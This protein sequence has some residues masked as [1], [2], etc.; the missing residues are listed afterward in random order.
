MHYT[1]FC[2]R[3]ELTPSPAWEAL[4]REAQQ[5]GEL[6]RPPC[7]RQVERFYT[8]YTEQVQAAAAHIAADPV[9]LR[10]YNLLRLHYFSCAES[11]LLPPR[12]GDVMRNFAPTLA[13]MANWVHTQEVLDTREVEEAVAAR[14]RSKLES[15]LQDHEENFGYPATAAMFFSWAVHYLRPD[16]YPIGALEFEVTTM[17]ENE[18]VY[19]HRETG[20]AV[21]LLNPTQ[22]DAGYTGT[23]YRRGGQTADPV[24]LPREAYT[25]WVAPGEDILSVHIPKGTDLSA[26]SCARTY[27]EARDFFARHYPDKAFKAFYCRSWLMDPDLEKLLS[28]G[29]RIASFQRFYA[30]Y[31]FPSNGGEVF[32]FVHPTPFNDYNELPERTTLER[33]LKQRYLDNDPIYR[34]AGLHDPE[35]V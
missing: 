20:G 13:M 34:Y 22:T 32:V 14:I 33:A 31:P 28:P 5:S 6:T 2:R 1:E 9:A 26:E 30:R 24:T 10:Y 16:L 3:A 25:L 8:V 35:G 29:S 12:R 4:Y 21:W 18:T 15:F 23:V 7:T 19:R 27:R 17:A 11:I